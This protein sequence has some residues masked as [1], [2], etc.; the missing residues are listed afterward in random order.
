[1][2]HACQRHKGGAEWSRTAG[3]GINLARSHHDEIDLGLLKTVLPREAICVGMLSSLP[4]VKHIEAEGSDELLESGLISLPDAVHMGDASA[5]QG[6]LRETRS[7][8]VSCKN[9]LCTPRRAS[10]SGVK[11]GP[12][13]LPPA[14]QV[15]T[16]IRRG[17]PPDMLVDREYDDGRFCIKAELY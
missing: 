16:S 2:M 14:L 3:H 6:G 7:V 13:V 12:D 5:S 17:V 15:L 1:M 4:G 9:Q 11:R 8:E 10:Y